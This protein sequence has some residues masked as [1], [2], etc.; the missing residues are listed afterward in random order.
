MDKISDY[1]VLSVVL[2]MLVKEVIRPLI[3]ITKN[4]L[5]NG[6][7]ST[8]NSGSNG[9]AKWVDRK[10]EFKTKGECNEVVKRMEDNY[11][12]VNEKLCNLEEGQKQILQIM[13]EGK[14]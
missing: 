12:Y 9:Y 5:K 6:I 11:K 3:S 2:W 13:L 8:T 10:N 7:K 4:S 14:S 1:G